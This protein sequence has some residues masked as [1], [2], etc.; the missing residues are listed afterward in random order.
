MKEFVF[1]TQTASGH[2]SFRAVIKLKKAKQ[3]V[4]IIKIN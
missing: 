1:F 4:V 3:M 2:A